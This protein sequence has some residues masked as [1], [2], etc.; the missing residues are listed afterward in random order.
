M[1]GSCRDPVN[2][3]EERVLDQPVVI[4]PTLDAVDEELGS[5]PEASDCGELVAGV[6]RQAGMRTQD[7][8]PLRQTPAGCLLSRC[9]VVMNTITPAN[10]AA[11]RLGPRAATASC[12]Q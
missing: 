3:F 2:L 5:G 12:S 11:R 10:A 6:H 9:D 8:E 7:H 4:L 1:H